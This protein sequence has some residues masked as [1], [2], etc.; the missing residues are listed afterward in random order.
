MTGME[1]AA[2][3]SVIHH[4]NPEELDESVRA[5]VVA[6]VSFGFAPDRLAVL[7]GLRLVAIPMAGINT[8]PVA[9]LREASVQV[10]NAHANGMWVA[11]RALALVL[12]HRG[13]IVRGDQDLRRGTWHGF[14]A[15]ESPRDSW[16]SLYDRPV[17]I[18]GTGSIG[19][20]TARF[21]SPLGV[22][23]RGFRR[24]AGTEGL[25]EGLFESLHTDIAEAVE[26]A[27]VV[28]C[29]LPLTA[30]TDGM[31]GPRE[32][33]AMQGALLVNVGRAAVIQEKALYDALS[34]G[35]LG[36][37]ALDTWYRYPDPPGSTQFPSEYPFWELDSVLLSPHLGGYTTSATTASAREVV[38]A[39][40]R[41]ITGGAEAG[42]GGT[43]DLEAGY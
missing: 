19:Q 21:L 20:W 5:D 15:G 34:G 27:E 11:E 31:V 22:R 43:V 39:V 26:G 24:R 7:P 4:R 2:G 8:L 28:V 35:V 13:M 23:L 40:A 16:E 3:V 41:W 30:S 33:A 25:P 42:A 17:A 12:A 18:L 36:G 32:L 14:A 6:M 1:H 10:V 29:T 37:A 9:A 38:D